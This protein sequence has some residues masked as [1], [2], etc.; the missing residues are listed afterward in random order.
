MRQIKDVLEDL[1]RVSG[2]IF[3][4]GADAFKGKDHVLG[5]LWSAVRKTL[6]PPYKVIAN[7]FIAEGDYVTVEAI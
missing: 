3:Q 4:P 5:D 6:N 1:V 7:N 2:R